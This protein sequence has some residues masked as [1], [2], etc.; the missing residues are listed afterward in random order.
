MDWADGGGD[1]EKWADLR[2]LLGVKVTGLRGGLESGRAEG[3][4]AFEC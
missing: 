4:G 1:G 2:A 3:V